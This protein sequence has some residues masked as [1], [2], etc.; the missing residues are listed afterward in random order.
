MKK[1]TKAIN[2]K[3]D[4][5]KD[6]KAEIGSQEVID[7]ELRDAKEIWLDDVRH[8]KVLSEKMVRF[9]SG[10]KVEN[11]ARFREDERRF[12]PKMNQEKNFTGTVP[13]IEKFVEFWGGIWEKERTTKEQP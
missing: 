10:R 12:Y 9:R 8:C 2:N 1:Y 7:Q 6:L 3:K 5:L 4:I 13:E 11:N